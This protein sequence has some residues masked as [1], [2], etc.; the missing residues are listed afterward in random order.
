[1]YILYWSVNVMVNNG[2]KDNWKVL[3]CKPLLSELLMFLKEVSYA[4]QRCT[5]LFKNTALKGKI[6]RYYYNLKFSILI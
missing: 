2:C 6:M 3:P 1:M 4:N 5:Y